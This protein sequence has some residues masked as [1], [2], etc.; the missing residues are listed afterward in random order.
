[1]IEHTELAAQFYVSFDHLR[2]SLQDKVS[3]Q[4][5]LDTIWTRFHQCFEETVEQ[6]RTAA[7]GLPYVNRSNKKGEL[8]RTTQQA[9][10]SSQRMVNIQPRPDSGVMLDDGSEESGSVTSSGVR[11]NDGDAVAHMLNNGDQHGFV[12]GDSSGTPALSLQ[13]PTSSFHPDFLPAGTQLIPRGHAMTSNPQADFTRI[14]TD[15]MLYNMTTMGVADPSATQNRN[16]E[17]TPPHMTF[18]ESTTPNL[19]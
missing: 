14:W 16:W 9:A 11:Y 6:C 15:E 2:A 19:F 4:E 5:T 17:D 1:M 8:G 7:Q 13:T 10:R 12:F 3:N 18:H